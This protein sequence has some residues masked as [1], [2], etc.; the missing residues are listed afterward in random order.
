MLLSSFKISKCYLFTDVTN[1]YSNALKM[2]AVNDHGI[3]L[4]VLAGALKYRV[5][6]LA[7]ETPERRI[8]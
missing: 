3:A 2:R 8:Q 4:R 6:E 5:P 1:A 7:V